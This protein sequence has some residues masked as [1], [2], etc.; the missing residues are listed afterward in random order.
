MAEPPA[1]PTVLHIDIEKGWRGGQQQVAYLLAHLW[2]LGVSPLLACAPGEPLE[3]RAAEEGWRALP[4]RGLLSGSLSLARL[5]RA[6]GIAIVHAH[7]SRAQNV[8]LLVRA[9]S[10]RVRVVVTRRVDFHRGAGPLHAWKYRT[11]RVDRWIAIS[12]RVREVLIEDGVPAGRIELIHSG[13]DP[14]RIAAAALAPAA[15]AALR[16]SLGAAEG[17][18]LIGGVGALAPHKDHGTLIHAAA[19]ARG[20]GAPIRLAIAGEGEQRAALERLI[21][22]LGAGGSV[23]LLGQRADV[24]ALLHAFDLFALSSREEGLGTSVLDAMAAGLAVVV[25][26]AGGL[27]EMVKDGRNGRVVPPGD[28][29]RL[30]A[31]LAE[32]ARDA[33][34]RA[35]C[36]ARNREDVR[37]F[38]ARRTAERTLAVYEALLEN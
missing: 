18:V 5:V 15:R 24:P 36:G 2:A 25:T 21:A 14:Q 32:M 12:A 16:A 3:R 11:A 38:T 10:P 7:A 4:V 8:A 17:D 26:E 33:A 13:V 37:H 9:L 23:R 6:E 1:A 35:E 34:L 31:A 22:A 27:P 28:V 19:L 20:R 30:A 29:E